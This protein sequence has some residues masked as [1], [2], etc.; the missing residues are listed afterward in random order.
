MSFNFVQ[1]NQGEDNNFIALSSHNLCNFDRFSES[2]FKSL[3]VNMESYI[4]EFNTIGDRGYVNLDTKFPIVD[5]FI[6]T[7][8]GGSID[9]KRSDD[10]LGTS[11][12]Y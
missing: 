7:F 2:D 6:N 9:E 5:D 8:N 11:S 3:L 1:S 10:D 12:L 4:N